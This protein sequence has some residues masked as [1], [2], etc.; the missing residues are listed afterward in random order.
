MTDKTKETESKKGCADCGN[1]EVMLTEEKYSEP[2][3][4]GCGKLIKQH[5]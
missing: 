4:A 5:K 3:C 2:R 1:E